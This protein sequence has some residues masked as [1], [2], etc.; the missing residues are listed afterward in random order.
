MENYYYYFLFEICLRH[1][2]VDVLIN[3][4]HRVTVCASVNL[5]SFLSFQL[6]KTVEGT[7][8]HSSLR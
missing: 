7:E 3:P 8:I 5:S 1:G 6:G 4:C 2:G